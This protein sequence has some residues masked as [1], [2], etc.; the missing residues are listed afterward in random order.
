MDSISESSAS[1]L[2]RRPVRLAILAALALF[3]AFMG[4]I[5]IAQATAAPPID[6]PRSI[7]SGMVVRPDGS[8]LVGATVSLAYSR[9]DPGRLNDPERLPPVTIED[10]RIQPGKDQFVSTT[11]KQGRFSI[12]REPDPLGFFFG[13]VIVHPEGYAEVSRDSILADTTVVAKPWGRI[14]G[15]A[16]VGAAPA[17]GTE[18]YRYNDRLGNPGFPSIDDSGKVMADAD[19][20]FVFDRVVPGDARV[21]RSF[22]DGPDAL[23]WL[24]GTLVEVRSGETSR[25]EVGGRG[26][27]V[28]ARVVAPRDFDPEDL[29][30]HSTFEI[31]TDQPSIPVEVMRLKQADATNAWWDSP[32]GHAYRRGHYLF[33][34]ARFRRDGMIR[35]EDVPPGNYVLRLSLLLDP[36]PGNFRSGKRDAFILKRFA[37]ADGPRD[38]PVDLGVIGP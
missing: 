4:A 38:V 34:K 16:R 24:N 35:V 36:P 25:V 15:V 5:E 23:T 7:L 29:S 1:D 2:A 28:V 33:N 31:E 30:I 9:S 22:G 10:G 19:G 26:R 20:R 6:E 13:V 27:T 17:G 21:T 18:I 3:A 8:P 14:E 12:A 11:D 37:I 32:E